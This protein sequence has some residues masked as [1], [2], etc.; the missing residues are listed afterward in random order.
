LKK[1][2]AAI[3]AEAAALRES[4][5]AAGFKDTGKDAVWRDHDL[6]RANA[7]VWTRT[8]K[9]GEKIELPGHTLD[10]VVLVRPAQP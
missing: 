1:P 8:V 9:G 10:Y 5:A 3:E 6:N 7:R 4:L 2:D